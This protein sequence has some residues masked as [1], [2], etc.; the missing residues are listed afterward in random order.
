MDKA[1]GSALMKFSFCTALELPGDCSIIDFAVCQRHTRISSRLYI[2]VFYINCLERWLSQKSACNDG[3]WLPTLHV[4]GI[5]QPFV[6]ATFTRE[7][8][9][10]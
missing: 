5:L 8:F 7:V 3:R 2:Q 9:D 4:V 1:K 6:A 10:S